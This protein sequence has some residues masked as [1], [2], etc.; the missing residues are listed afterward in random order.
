MRTQYEKTDLDRLV[1]SIF[2]CK[3]IT[4]KG[5]DKVL[6]KRRSQLNF[7]CSR[8]QLTRKNNDL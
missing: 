5:S 6:W 8:L 7:L 3:S 2:E 1:P 4:E